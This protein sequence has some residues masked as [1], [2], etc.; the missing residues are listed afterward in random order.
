MITEQYFYTGVRDVGPGF[1]ITDEALLEALS[2]TGYTQAAQVGHGVDAGREDHLAW[3]VLGWKLRIFRR[4]KLGETIRVQT[5]STGPSGIRYGRDFEVYDRAGCRVAAASS[6]WVAMNAG[7]GMILKLSP[8]DQDVYGSVPDRRVFPEFT[9]TRKLREDLPFSK[10]VTVPVHPT[11]IDM[12]R[13]VHN[14]VYPAMAA[15]ALPEGMDLNR[16]PDLEILYKHQIRPDETVRLRYA[17]ED[18]VHYVLI[19]NSE[20]G[21][22]HALIT[23]REGPLS[24]D[25]EGL[26][27]TGSQA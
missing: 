5:W 21:T 27:N 6:L 1:E 23:L 20:D 19:A 12:N 10:E 14:T 8:E 3:F 2:D 13:H 17:E 22:G 9:F 26:R 7:T 25:Q 24:Q 16:F 11:M 18:G 15:L 4:P